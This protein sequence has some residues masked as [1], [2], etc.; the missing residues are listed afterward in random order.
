MQR[1]DS[2]ESANLLN[3]PS[4]PYFTMSSFALIK[5]LLLVAVAFQ[6]TAYTIVRRLSRGVNEES[7]SNASVLLIIEI[8][9]FFFSL[10]IVTFE[11]DFS[12]MHI[13][14]TSLPLLLP[15]M[16]YL[17]MNVLSFIAIK[18]VDATTFIVIIQ[19][20]LL[21]TALFSICIMGK[22]ISARRWRSLITLTIGVTLIALP[23]GEPTNTGGS[24]VSR[25]ENYIFGVLA[26]LIEVVLS[27]FTSVFFESTLK[28]SEMSVWGRNVQLSM[29]S[30]LIYASTV[31][32]ETQTDMFRGWTPLAVA[33]ALLGAL[34]GI[35][36]A[37]A[38]RF[39]DS[40]SKTIATSSCIILT[41]LFNSFLLGEPVTLHVVLYVAVVVMA[42]VEYVHGA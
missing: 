2:S 32:A 29:W 9:K 41:C 21:T 8:L 42:V 24:S 7:Y 19:L 18:H 5:T 37:L 35:L 36:V 20:K 22:S 27:G 39:T 30:I 6:S 34:G 4:N 10:L 25:D 33:C 23:S 11:R 1:I 14:T 3:D 40:L 13:V 15:A 28:S 16:G 26:V 12:L 38:L 31:S 17:V